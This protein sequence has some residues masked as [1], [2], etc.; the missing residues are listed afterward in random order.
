MFF[1]WLYLLLKILK[2]IKFGGIMKEQ[3]K[4]LIDEIPDDDLFLINIYNIIKAF[5]VRSEYKKE[6]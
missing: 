5:L 3:I 6:A 1:I 4:K 2:S